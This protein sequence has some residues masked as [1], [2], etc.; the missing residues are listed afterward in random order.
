MMLRI[1]LNC[2]RSSKATRSADGRLLMLKTDH[3]AIQRS[4]RLKG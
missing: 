4:E 2:Y 1:L 3:S